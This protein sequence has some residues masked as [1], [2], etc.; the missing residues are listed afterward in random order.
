[1]SFY[2]TTKKTYFSIEVCSQITKPLN[3]VFLPVIFCFAYIHQTSVLRFLPIV[4]VHFIRHA[5]LPFSSLNDYLFAYEQ[6][7]SRDVKQIII[8]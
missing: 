6:R 4:P 5:F 8:T 1:M 3:R 7:G 2:S